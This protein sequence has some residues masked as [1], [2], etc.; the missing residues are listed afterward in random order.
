VKTKLDRHEK[1]RR[2]E[3][4]DKQHAKPSANAPHHLT[5]AE[6]KALANPVKPLMSPRDYVAMVFHVDPKP[7]TPTKKHFIK[8]RARRLMGTTETYPNGEPVVC[9]LGGYAN[10]ASHV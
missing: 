7:E 3:W 1:N 9:E 8:A 2:Q 4:R 5:N 6:R 10:G